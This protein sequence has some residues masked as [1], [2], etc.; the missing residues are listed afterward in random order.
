M[1]EES[2]CGVG[3]RVLS[4]IFRNSK[5][6]FF[7]QLKFQSSLNEKD[8]CH[9]I[10]RT[11][12]EQG[13]RLEYIFTGIRANGVGFNNETRKPLPVMLFDRKLLNTVLAIS[14]HIKSN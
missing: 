4:A 7:H 5:R 2:L 8:S 3:N 1:V 14:I 13:C 12:N 9:V 10:P 6:T 11:N